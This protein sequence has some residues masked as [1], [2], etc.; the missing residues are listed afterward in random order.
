M[1][2]PGHGG[3]DYG[4][5]SRD[6]EVREKDINLNIVRILRKIVYTE[7]Y[8]FEVYTT[9]HEDKF[10][11]LW[12]RVDLAKFWVV[13]AFMSIH[14]NA[15]EAIGR[16]GL[17]VEVFH[18][19]D[20]R[21]GRN[22]ANLALGCLLCETRKETKVISRGVKEKDFYVLRHTL[23]P[24]ILVELGFITDPEEA[25]FLNDKKNQKILAKALIE[26]TQLY[27]ES[28]MVRW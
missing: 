1:I 12:N 22:F 13:H 28:G 9:R 20:S 14:C 11:P 10:I 21:K 23:C 6:G 27:F 16:D 2:D 7:D 8:P 24:A 15:R 3:A 19:V 25:G 18:A 5:V 26:A 4:A 17:E